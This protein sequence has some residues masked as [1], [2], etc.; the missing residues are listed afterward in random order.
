[1]APRTR[2]SGTMW[3]PK[4]EVTTWPFDERTRERLSQY[5]HERM[6]DLDVVFCGDDLDLRGAHLCG[7]DFKLGWFSGSVLDK[8]RMLAAN[9]SEAALDGASLEQ[10]DLTGCVLIDADLSHCRGRRA[11]LSWARL[12]RAEIY[13]ADLRE[14]DLLGAE[15]EGAVLAGADLRGAR[16]QDVRFARTV[17]KGVRL[18]DCVVAGARGTVHGPIDVSKTEEPE[19]LDGPDMVEWFREHQARV[20][21]PQRT[22]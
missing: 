14:A 12:A 8:V 19:L 15:L 2:P 4:L 3:A 6:R 22:S 11:V 1:M 21:L 20:T 5:R 17:L 9:L 18:A 13:E 7:F 16:L 10:A